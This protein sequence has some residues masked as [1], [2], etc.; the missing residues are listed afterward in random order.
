MQ[1][2]IV[3]IDINNKDFIKGL[4]K[5]G[6]EVISLENIEELISVNSEF[7]LVLISIKAAKSIKEEQLEQFYFY[8]NRTPTAV[9]TTQGNEA[10][11][12]IPH[13]FDILFES[14][15][16][17]G[18]IYKCVNKLIAFSNLN[19]EIINMQERFN[20]E[21][22]LA[23]EL[24]LRDQLLSHERGISANILSSITSAVI[25]T[26]LEG[27]IV[28]LNS[29][30]EEI[31]PE[32]DRKDI[33]GSSYT[34]LPHEIKNTVDDLLT[35]DKLSFP[36][37]IVRKCTVDL[38][39]LKIYGYYLKT[40]NDEKNGILLLIND[41]T[42]E[43]EVNQ[44]LY[45]SEKLATVGTMLS[46]IAHELRNPLSIISA[47]VQMA[48]MK[49]D[50]T[51]E[52]VNKVLTTV[53]TQT[54]RCANIVNSLLNFTRNT[55][56]NAGYH[57]VTEVLDETLNYVNYQK[58][59]DNIEV[60]KEYDK[61]RLVF[62]D[63]SRFVQIFINLITNAAD[64][65]EGSGKLVIKTAGNNDGNTLI[66]ISDN[67]PGIDTVIENKLFDP[68]FTTKEPGKG[69]GLGLSIVYK[70]V[71]ESNGKI[72]FESQPGHT[73]FFVE[74]PAEKERHLEL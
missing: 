60:I 4:K 26:D 45:R 5:E 13:S 64:A 44:L 29:R 73:T 28:L 11:S 9:L 19:F 47:R 57:K 62:G 49:K 20:S 14:E 55:A 53:E 54:D 2:S 23:H 51:E 42:E 38:M 68:F 61:S 74:L 17:Y 52:S 59:F 1:T 46:G 65:M 56:T 58:T 18:S 12:K 69:T 22:K 41:V 35:T 36:T 15:V 25:I 43:E 16:K 40:D 27:N 3:T 67:G 32:S 37:G 33:I 66:T 71:S 24:T 34:K 10:N 31:I 48:Q 39:V 70:I 30:A 72:R 7:N 50:L 63:R 21:S 8:N 6:F